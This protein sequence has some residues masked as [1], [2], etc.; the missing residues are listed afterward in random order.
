MN[1]VIVAFGLL[2]TVALLLVAPTP[3]VRALTTAPKP[4]AISVCQI[5]SRHIGSDADAGI[6]A[7]RGVTKKRTHPGVDVARA[8]Q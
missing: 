8:R 1:H 2:F 4:I 7:A 3:A 5:S 6:E